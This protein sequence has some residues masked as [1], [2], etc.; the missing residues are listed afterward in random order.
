MNLS[1]Y[2]DYNIIAWLIVPTLIFIGA[3]A[4]VTIGTLRIIFVS[5]GKRLLSTILGFG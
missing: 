1:T 4:Y 2:F 5:R 3:L